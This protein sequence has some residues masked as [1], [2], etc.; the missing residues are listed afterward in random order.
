MDSE[1]S[2]IPAV[3]IKDGL[4]MR[5]FKISSSESA[6]FLLDDLTGLAKATW[7]SARAD[8][9]DNDFMTPKAN[10]RQVGGME[11]E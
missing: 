4:F 1:C 9:K 2:N 3:G 6:P 10:Y 8:N 5:T 7:A 11:K